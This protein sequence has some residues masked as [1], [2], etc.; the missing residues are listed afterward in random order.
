MWKYCNKEIVGSHRSKLPTSAIVYFQTLPSRSGSAK[1]ACRLAGRTARASDAP[2]SKFCTMRFQ[3]SG[4][5]NVNNG[6]C[7]ELAN[8]VQK[9]SPDTPAVYI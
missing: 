8:D 1:S 5:I 2:D 7:K 9:P 6:M 3:E 4:D